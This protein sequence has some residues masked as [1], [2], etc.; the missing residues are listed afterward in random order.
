M[1][2]LTALSRRVRDHVNPRI[3]RTVLR[4]N[5]NGGAAIFASF[6]FIEAAPMFRKVRRPKKVNFDCVA[7]S[8]KNQRR[9]AERGSPTLINALASDCPDAP[10]APQ[11]GEVL[12]IGTPRR[13]TAV[14]CEMMV[15]AHW[16]SI[17]A[18]FGAATRRRRLN[19]RLFS[20]SASSRPLRRR[21]YIHC[22]PRAFRRRADKRR[23]FRQ[24]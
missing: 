16:L 3:D 14:G 22:P 5:L 12:M 9:I 11:I 18:S 6:K 20:D 19:R 7:V 17:A 10:L 1:R 21:A 23:A 15:E 13:Q 24:T 8:I 4:L 2:Q